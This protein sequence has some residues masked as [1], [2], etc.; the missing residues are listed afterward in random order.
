[1]TDSSATSTSSVTF[2]DN[3]VSGGGGVLIAPSGSSKA[4]IT[5]DGNDI[6]DSDANG[7]GVDDGI[8][9]GTSVT[10][11]GT[12]SGNTVGTPTTAGA[13]NDIG[14]YAEGTGTE[15]LAI[16]NNSLFQYADDAGINFLDRE[17]SPTMNLTITG[18]TI[19]DPGTFGSWGLLGQAGAETGDAGKVCAAIS[20]NSLKGSAAQNQ[21]GADIELDQEFATTIELPGYNGGSQDTNAVV[22]FLTANNNTGN[23]TF[24]GIATTSGSGGGFT[25]P[26]SCPAPS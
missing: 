17:G 3:T 1:M 13:G 23:D 18:N 10:L 20:G 15:T 22:T 8:N 11:S 19:A 12:I 7:I 2:S 14:I 16:T 21:G 4:K 26:T 9:P 24:G 5:V 25:G 6:K